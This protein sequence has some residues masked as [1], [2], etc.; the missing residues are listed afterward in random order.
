M[1]ITKREEDGRGHL[2]YPEA[3]RCPYQTND[4]L[5]DD[6]TRGGKYTR[7]IEVHREHLIGCDV[8]FRQTAKLTR[9]CHE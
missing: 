1:A 4:S 5:L 2:E 9:V 8:A 7:L 6:N 3:I